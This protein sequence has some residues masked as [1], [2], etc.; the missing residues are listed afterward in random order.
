MNTISI[1]AAR[2]IDRHRTFRL[3]TGVILDGTVESGSHG[4][5]DVARGGLAAASF[6][7]RA[8][9]GT[10]RSPSIDLSGTFGASWTSTSDVATGKK[11]DYFATDLRVGASAGW[12]L[13]DRTWSY[14]TARVFGGPVN[15]ELNGESVTGTDT[16]HYQLGLGSSMRIGAFGLFAEWV[17]L[18]EK[19]LSTGISGSW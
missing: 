17:G 2:L 1:S 4:K 18:G 14:L 13:L 15:W 6:E 12:S 19:A 7:Y 8:K 10:D 11:A 16:H 5:H 3:A 9:E